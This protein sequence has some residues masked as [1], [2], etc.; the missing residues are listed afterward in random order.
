MKLTY[1]QRLKLNEWAAELLQ[2]WEINQRAA[3]CDPPFEVA[4]LQLKWARKKAGV[5]FRQDRAKTDQEAI[6]RGEAQR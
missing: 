5:R 6:A 3:K 2:L 1:E 4:Y